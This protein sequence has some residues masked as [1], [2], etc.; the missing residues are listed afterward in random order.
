MT[1]PRISALAEAAWGTNTSFSGYE[2]RLVDHLSLYWNHGIYYFN[3]FSPEE[4]VE[5]VE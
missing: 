4:L 5:P 2:E 3:P 1:F